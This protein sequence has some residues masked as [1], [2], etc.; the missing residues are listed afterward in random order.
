MPELQPCRRQPWKLVRPAKTNAHAILTSQ[1]KSPSQTTYIL[2]P[3][4]EIP[5]PNLFFLNDLPKSGGAVANS[6][7]DF[8]WN[9]GMGFSLLFHSLSGPTNIQTVNTKFTSLQFGFSSALAFQ[10][11]FPSLLESKTLNSIAPHKPLY[12]LYITPNYSEP[13]A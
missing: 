4:H 2:D 12:S 9:G 6:L 8:L 11:D 7:T 13:Y 3:E 1:C 5:H 10:F